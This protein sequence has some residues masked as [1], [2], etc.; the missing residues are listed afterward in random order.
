MGKGHEGDLDIAKWELSFVVY[1][2]KVS[3]FITNLIINTKNLV[4]QTSVK[5]FQKYIRLESPRLVKARV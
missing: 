2:A 4:F 5:L 1:A 3:S